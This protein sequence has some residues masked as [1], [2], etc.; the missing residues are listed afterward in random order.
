MFRGTFN[1]QAVSYRQPRTVEHIVCQGVPGVPCDVVLQ[2][3]DRSRVS[4][5]IC[6]SCAVETEAMNDYADYRAGRIADPR[7]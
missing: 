2:Q 6:A 3:G 5:G 1:S 4:H 7:D